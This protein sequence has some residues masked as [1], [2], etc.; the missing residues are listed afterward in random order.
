MQEI[1]NFFDKM[2]LLGYSKIEVQN[3]LTKQLKKESVFKR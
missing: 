1:Q 3:L 2:S